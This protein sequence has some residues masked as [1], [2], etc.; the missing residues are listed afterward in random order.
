M[1]PAP[2]ASPMSS[3]VPSYSNDRRR[4]TSKPYKKPSLNFPPHP[5]W[6]DGV[7]IGLRVQYAGSKAARFPRQSGAVEVPANLLREV[8]EDLTAVKMGTAS[9]KTGNAHFSSQLA[10]AVDLVWPAYK[11][12]PLVDY[13]ISFFARVRP[14]ALAERSISCMAFYLLP[15]Y[16]VSLHNHPLD[17]GLRDFVVDRHTV[18]PHTSALFRDALPSGYPS[19][20]RQRSDRTP[21][22]PPDSPRV[23]REPSSPTLMNYDIN[24]ST[25]STR[26]DDVPSL[27][28]P[29]LPKNVLEDLPGLSRKRPRETVDDDDDDDEQ[30]LPIK[31]RRLI[32]ERDEAQER[33]R[34]LQQEAS[35]M[36]D[37][38]RS[39]AT[40]KSCIAVTERR[41]RRL[42]DLLDTVFGL[43]SPTK[44]SLDMLEHEF[45]LLQAK[46]HSTTREAA[47]AREGLDAQAAALG[48]EDGPGLTLP[49]LL[50]AL[51]RISGIANA[52]GARVSALL[53]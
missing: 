44:D 23:K 29:P 34:L 2:I 20:S 27:L 16:V 13:F 1:A 28:P 39:L 19:P 50:D 38:E 11:M 21:Y 3:Y 4:S 22:R 41:E 51:Q 35:Q 25:E 37:L 40:Y 30:L 31:I 15:P 9:P 36:P 6:P 49:V 12:R 5:D 10:G 53:R 26:V 14:E 46:T 45:A 18:D 52:S 24:M 32:A 33:E 43:T 48:F 17:K 42:T 7:T 47:Q 8:R